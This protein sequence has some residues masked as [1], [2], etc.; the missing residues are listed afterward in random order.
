M[1]RRG[2]SSR[3]K[4][5]CVHCSDYLFHRQFYL[6]PCS[7][8]FHSNCLMSKLSR[9]LKP[10]ICQSVQLIEEQLSTLQAR[11]D[12]ADKKIMAQQEILQSELDNLIAADCPECGFYMI[13]SLEVPLVHDEEE[14]KSWQI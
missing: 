4:Q 14:A 5:R 13:E 9:V 3:N 1:K 10:S 6:F 2:Y 7:H 12:S 8:G 11:K